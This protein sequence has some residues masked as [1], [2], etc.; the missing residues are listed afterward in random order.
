MTTCLLA[1]SDRPECLKKLD[2]EERC[3]KDRFCGVIMKNG[4]ESDGLEIHVAGCLVP[5]FCPSEPEIDDCHLR[6]LRRAKQ[7]D[8]YSCCCT[9]NYCNNN[10][11]HNST[12][13]KPKPE[14]TTTTSKF[15][16]L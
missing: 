9:S 14:T 8:I 4:T 12:L 1:N 3:E 5:S 2:C 10:T 6:H 15:F 13:M 16:L 7:F 11:V